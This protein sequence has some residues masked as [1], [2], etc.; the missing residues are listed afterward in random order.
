MHE[1]HVE[2]LVYPA[3]RWNFRSSAMMVARGRFRSRRKPWT[4]A[5]PAWFRVG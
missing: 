2:R 3:S 1:W 4:G 5:I